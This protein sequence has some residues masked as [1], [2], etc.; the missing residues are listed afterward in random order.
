MMFEVA[1]IIVASVIITVVL[2]ATWI[3]FVF[4]TE[5]LEAIL[6]PEE[7]GIVEEVDMRIA[8][9][10]ANIRTPAPQ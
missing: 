7:K 3:T 8:S 4:G 10:D 2:A 9:N 1:V 5:A 6:T